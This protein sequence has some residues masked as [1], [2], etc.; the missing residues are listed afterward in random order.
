MSDD[1]GEF[2]ALK[3]SIAREA[4]EDADALARAQAD[5]EARGK[6]PFDLDRPEQ[7]YDTV[8]ELA[9]KHVESHGERWRKWEY[10]YYVRAPGVMTLAEFAER[11]RR[12]D[13]YR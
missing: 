13:P 1:N 2:N 11:E 4:K 6:E 9:S 3:R 10:R 8:P 7:L 5:A 12:L